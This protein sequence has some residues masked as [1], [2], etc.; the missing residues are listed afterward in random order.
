MEV[1][2]WLWKVLFNFN[3]NA[4]TEVDPLI[5]FGRLFHALI[6]EGK[7]DSWKRF[8][9]DLKFWKWSAFLSG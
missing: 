4:E 7:N 1:F 3:L 8:E 2:W 6:I 9:F 5:S